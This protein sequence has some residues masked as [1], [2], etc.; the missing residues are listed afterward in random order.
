MKKIT[1]CFV[2]ILACAAPVFAGFNI[3]TAAGYNYVSMSNLNRNIDAAFEQAKADPDVLYASKQHVTDGWFVGID[4]DYTFFPGLSAGPRVEYVGTFGAQ[5][6][7]RTT[8]FP[9]TITAATA[10]LFAALIPVMAGVSYLYSVPGLPLSF[11]AEIYLGYGF[12]SLAVNTT[13]ENGFLAA[14][15]VESFEGSCFALES[16]FKI[17]YSFNSTFSAGINAGYRSAN[18]T[19]LKYTKVGLTL[20]NVSNFSENLQLDFSGMK[21]AAAANFSF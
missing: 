15:T 5:I 9:I 6:T 2:I 17:S 12:A 13:M 16:S 8:G 20:P 10:D 7:M 1:F 3:E 11:G 19:K 21:L 4:G 18:V 14:T